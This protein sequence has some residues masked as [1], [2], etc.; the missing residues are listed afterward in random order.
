MRPINGDKKRRRLMLLP[1]IGP[2]DGR[3]R[4]ALRF[5][6]MAEGMASDRGGRD[7]LTRGEEAL[8]RRAAGLEVL[9]DQIEERLVNGQDID[10]SDYAN[11]VGRQTRVLL[12][13]GLDRRA[14]T[15]ELGS[16]LAEKG[17]AA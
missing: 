16:Y 4:P 13:L 15:V 10:I 7:M 6:E 17:Q 3:R 11:V 9:A 12:A 8:I 5:R 14:K 2:I 1:E